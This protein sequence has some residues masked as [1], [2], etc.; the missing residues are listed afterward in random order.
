MLNLCR[1]SNLDGNFKPWLRS[2]NFLQFHISPYPMEP[3]KAPASFVMLRST[4]YDQPLPEVSLSSHGIFG[5]RGGM[6]SRYS[7]IS[8]ISLYQPSTEKYILYGKV[9]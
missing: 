7:I 2:A 1:L 8:F 9:P 3:V 4:P 5:S 6:P